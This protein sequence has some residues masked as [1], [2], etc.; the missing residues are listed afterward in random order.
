MRSKKGKTPF[1]GSFADWQKAQERY[2]RLLFDVGAG[3]QTIETIL[4]APAVV[5]STPA[6]GTTA[7]YSFFIYGPPEKIEAAARK[8]FEHFASSPERAPDYRDS[9][10]DPSGGGRLYISVIS[11]YDLTPTLKLLGIGSSVLAYPVGVTS[12]RRVE[13]ES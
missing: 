10:Y 11:A 3:W 8:L 9:F 6:V 5:P 7:R 12:P 2:S 13:H 1:A 4:E